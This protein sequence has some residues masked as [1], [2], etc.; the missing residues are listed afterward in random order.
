MVTY[1]GDPIPYDPAKSPEQIRDECK[2][3]IEALIA[4]HQRKP[5]SI[6]VGLYER[7]TKSHIS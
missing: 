2:E 1:I 7:F 4:K 5:G 6:C 3:A